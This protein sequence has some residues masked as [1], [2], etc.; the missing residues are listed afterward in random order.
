[1]FCEE[2]MDFVTKDFY[3]YDELIILLEINTVF[4]DLIKKIRN[5]ISVR[6]WWNCVTVGTKFNVLNIIFS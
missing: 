6:L 3:K 4:Y 1:M 2:C 5:I